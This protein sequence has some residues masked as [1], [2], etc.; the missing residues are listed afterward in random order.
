MIRTS[1]SA[2]H[3]KASSLLPF[4]T[5]ENRPLHIR[6]MTTTALQK[7]E[8]LSIASVI[9]IMKCIVQVYRTPISTLDSAPSLRPT[10]PHTYTIEKNSISI[11]FHALDYKRGFNRRV[12]VRVENYPATDRLTR[13]ETGSPPTT[14]TI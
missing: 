6:Y 7:P 14:Y 4:T 10:V 1:N 8:P 13:Q 5:S 9:A 11:L 2:I 3:S 12:E